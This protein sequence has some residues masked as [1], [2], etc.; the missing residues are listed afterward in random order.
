M[1]PRPSLAAGASELK[2]RLTDDNWRGV[3]FAVNVFV[4]STLTW[5]ILRQFTNADPIWAMA[6]LVAS[7]EPVVDQALAMFRSRLINTL[8]GC[9]VGLTFLSVGQP[10]P[11]KLP[12]ALAIAVLLSAYVVRIQ[13][14]WRQ[15]PITAAIV[16]GGSLE[17]HSRVVGFDHGLRRVAEVL[18]GCL[19][20]LAVS[21]AMSRLWPLR[22]KDD[23]RPKAP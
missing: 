1:T 12:F 9:A 8:L 11:W 20:A 14:M 5:I 10:E 13:V 18:V 6:S 17:S 4:A 15:A 22:P 23:P 16:I 3:H 19:I 2:R 7:S 21:W